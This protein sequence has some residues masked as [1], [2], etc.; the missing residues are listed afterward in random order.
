MIR[1]LPV[2]A[3]LPLLLLGGCGE[4][5][6]KHEEVVR[7][8]L[9]MVVAPSQ[10]TEQGFVGT[11]EPQ[12]SAALAFR[13]LGRVISRDVGV[14]DAVSAGAILASIDASTLQLQVQAAG[15]DVASAE[16][17]YA[18]AAASEERQKALLESK[19]T[20]QA[21]YDAA[22][23]ARDSARAN[24]ESTRAALAKAQEQLGYAQLSADF[25]GVVTATG[26]E[27]GQ[28]VSPGQMVVTIARADG[29]D[30]VVDCP[31][32]VASTL[33]SGAEFEVSLQSAP[34]I[35]AVARV[36]E[37]APQADA[38]TRTRRVK[39][40]LDN[41][42]EQFRLGS[43]VNLR[44][45]VA[46]SSTIVLPASALLD[47]GG[48]TAVWIVESGSVRLI[49]ITVG[50]TAPGFFTVATGIEPGQRVVTAGVHSLRDGQKVKVDG[51]GPAS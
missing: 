3:L 27:I 29:R 25:D 32:D 49:P 13:M 48:R 12:T 38:A 28:V 2:V 37:I 5:E 45:A 4:E 11:I 40:A 41:A 7:P 30:A 9:S 39:L 51:E 35:K 24:L 42:P 23:Q 16:A 8:V 34:T 26:A 15:A 44:R 1:V 18:N 10:K 6:A 21:V 22:L 19:N 47:E 14:G 36:R 31:D 43:T 17:Q 33:Q 46:A 20:P 50:A